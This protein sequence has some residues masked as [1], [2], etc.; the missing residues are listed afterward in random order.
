MKEFIINKKKNVK[1]NKN[2]LNIFIFILIDNYRKMFF[3]KG[4]ADINDY[5]LKR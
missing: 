1:L 2:Q 3:G 4:S 5:T